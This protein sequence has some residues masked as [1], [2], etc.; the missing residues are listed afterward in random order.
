MLACAIYLIL[1]VLIPA[2]MSHHAL[3][4]PTKLD[5]KLWAIYWAIFAIF[6]SL[7]WNIWLLNYPVVHFLFCVFALWLYHEN[8]KVFMQYI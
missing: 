6:K 2:K 1:T 7:Q 4:T 8:Y 3:S 5:N